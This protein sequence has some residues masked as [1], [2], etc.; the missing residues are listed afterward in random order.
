MSS[1]VV[2]SGP[3]LVSQDN[4]K[5]NAHNTENN[6]KC[7]EAF[8]DTVGADILGQSLSLRTKLQ[9]RVSHNIGSWIHFVFVIF[10]GS[11]AH[12]EELFIAIG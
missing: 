9:A 11:R 12:T 8:G 1:G 10:S 5:T 6:T 7:K 3:R 4:I 2:D